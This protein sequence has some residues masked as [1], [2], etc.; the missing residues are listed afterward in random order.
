MMTWEENERRVDD[1]YAWFKANRPGIIAGHHG[2]KAA[3]RDHRVWGY[4]P[5]TRAAMDYM[6]AHGIED[7]D[8][9]VQD[10]LTPEEESD[11][12]SSIFMGFI[13]ANAL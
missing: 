5:N 9:A 10:C 11:R 1:E 2:Q 7:G 3:I 13:G 6:E 12:N 4:F 8:Y